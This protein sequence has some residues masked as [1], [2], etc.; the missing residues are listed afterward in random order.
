MRGYNCAEVCA[1]PWWWWRQ[2]WKR[3]QVNHILAAHLLR[4]MRVFVKNLCRWEKYCKNWQ[5]SGGKI[6][7]EESRLTSPEIDRLEN[8]ESDALEKL[9]PAILLLICWQSLDSYS[10]F[11]CR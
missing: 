2:G 5:S 6:L 3:W 10:E 7:K 4:H 9:K 1:V 11:V 8:Y